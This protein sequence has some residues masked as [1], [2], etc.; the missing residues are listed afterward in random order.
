[1]GLPRILPLFLLPRLPR[2][3]RVLDGLDSWRA[4]LEQ[5]HVEVKEA[6]TADLVVAPA[7]RAADAIALAPAAIVLEGRPPRGALQHAGYAARTLLALPDADEPEV[8]VPAGEAG[9]VGYAFAS[10]S[11]LRS[12]VARTVLARGLV[13]P[14]ASPTVI[15]ARDA[16][17]PAFV[18]GAAA[19][20]PGPVASWLPVL[21]RWGDPFS[22]GVLL[23]FPPG[24]AEPTW[25]LKFARVPGN[26]RPFAL[27]EQ[28]LGLAAAAGGTVAA[29]APRFLGRFTV[30]RLAASLETATVGRRLLAVLGGSLS[31]ERKLAEVERVAAWIEAVATE[32]SGKAGTLET[33]RA[34]LMEG[35]LPAWAGRGAPQDLADRLAGLPTVFEHADLWPDN[36]V[37]ADGSF[38][39]LDWESARAGGAP[40][41]DLLYF[42][43]AALAMVDGTSSEAQEEE[44]FVRLHRGEL[45]SSQVLFAWIRRV[46]AASQVPPEAVGPLATLRLLSLAT[47]DLR[48]AER[49]VAAGAAELVPLSA[50]QTIRWL[51]DPALG[52]GWT[53]WR[54]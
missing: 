29:H 18:S 42:M 50:R 53:A 21:G 51:E 46:G 4:G 1:M 7:S 10:R 24:A 43:T 23:L 38:G 40:L 31:R 6:G 15:A 47:E 49:T 33:E 27:D 2:T 11:G 13:P 36:I 39:T 5:A 3:A 14:P 12:R 17:P 28:G 22:R 32:T 37:V 19:L 45:P 20:L 25:A 16:G 54:A 9:P 35:V 34:R 48:H 52:P 44:H 30:D 26:E 41:W 8:L